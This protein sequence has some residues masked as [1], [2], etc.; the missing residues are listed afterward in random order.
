[1]PQDLG[2]KSKGWYTMP[3]TQ[4]TWVKSQILNGSLKTMRS[5][6]QITAWCGLQKAKTINKIKQKIQN[7][8][9]NTIGPSIYKQ[10]IIIV[11]SKELKQQSCIVFVSTLN[12]T[13][14]LCIQPLNYFLFW[15]ICIQ[16]FSFRLI[17]SFNEITRFCIII[18]INAQNR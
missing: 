7:K 16:N 9:K 3:C 5:E 1:M 4:K 10:F 15:G 12:S 17:L 8:T 6:Y 14:C 18:L 13:L 11:N 2:N